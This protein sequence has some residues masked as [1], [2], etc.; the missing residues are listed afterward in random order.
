MYI[1]WYILRLTTL[2]NLPYMQVMRTGIIG[3][4]FLICFMDRY[5]KKQLIQLLLFGVIGIAGWFFSDLPDILL[6]FLFYSTSWNVEVQKL[7]KMSF[8]VYCLMIFTVYVLFRMGVVTDAI[9]RWTLSG[10]SGHSYGYAHANMLAMVVL[11]PIILWLYH[12]NNKVKMADYLVIGAIAIFIYENTQARTM[13]V[14][15]VLLLVLIP[16]IEFLAKMKKFKSI[17]KV[18]VS[19]PI[20]CSIIS[21]LVTILY[22]MNVG[23][24]RIINLRLS[25][26]IYMQLL[27]IQKYGISLFPSVQ[28]YNEGATIESIIYLDSSYIKLAVNFGFIIFAVVIAIYTNAMNMMYK[29][30]DY[31]AL[32]IAAVMCIMGLVETTLYRMGI[33]IFLLVL[34]EY[35]R[36]NSV[37]K[38]YAFN[39]EN[40]R[41]IKKFDRTENQ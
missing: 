12:R 17:I 39:A 34:F 37:L 2:G 9:K 27:A 38:M 7:Q 16:N 25:N 21:F 18:L 10:I 1:C 30:G 15:I 13:A 29:H 5:S 28:I 4:L 36:A 20:V 11:Q 14:I 19:T 35:A 31:R 26:R 23:F 8:I 24:V 33:N 32:S 22:S 3:L 6:F 41:K 40:I